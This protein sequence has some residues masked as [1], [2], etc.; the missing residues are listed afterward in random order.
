MSAPAG[1]TVH[2]HESVSMVDAVNEV[3]DELNSIRPHNFSITMIRWVS[4]RL[5]GGVWWEEQL[6]EAVD[7]A[8]NNI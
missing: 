2:P 3:I 1:V 7:D 8:L 6:V 5:F 4:A